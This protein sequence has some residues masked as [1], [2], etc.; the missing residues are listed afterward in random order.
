MAIAGIVENDGE[1]NSIA[2]KSIVSGGD[3]EVGDILR[4]LCE[5]AHDY[6][7][8]EDETQFHLLPKI[9]NQ[10]LINTRFSMGNKQQSSLLSMFPINQ[11]TLSSSSL[12][13]AAA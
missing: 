5:G 10:L 8:D 6:E 2:C 3:V 12:E 7:E 13:P 9:Y 11:T 1:G 4:L